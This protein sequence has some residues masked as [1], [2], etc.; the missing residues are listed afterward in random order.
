MR[1]RHPGGELVHL[2]YCTNV[3]PA[4]D[5]DGILAQL[6]TYALP[7][8]ERLEEP[9]L[10][11]GLWLAH[12]VAAALA[13]DAGL[14]AR[15]RAELGARGLEVVTLNG[16][17]YGGFHQ[18]VVK[19]DVYRPDWTSPER[20]RYTTDLAHV[21][22]RLLP[23]DVREGS[24]STLPLGWRT[25][26]QPHHSDLARHQIELLGDEL[27]EIRRRTGRTVRVAF[28]P[29]PGCLVET[30]GD[31]VRHLSD[32]D[33]GHFGLCLDICHLAVAFE[34]PEEVLNRLTAAG[35]PV[36]KAQ[37]SCALHA[38]NPADPGTR[39]ALAA[40]AEPRFLHQTRGAG[41]P[42]T[43]TDDLPEALAGP[44]VGGSPW[45]T[46]FHIP[47]HA[48]PVP[49]LA[50]T[51]PVLRS[52]L[53]ALLRTGHPVTR[54]F[55]TETYTWSVLPEPPRDSAGLIDG[56]AAELDWTRRELLGLGLSR[57][58]RR[59]APERPSE[60]ESGWDRSPEPNRSAR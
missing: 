35:I 41:P 25:G 56:I 17:P 58:E 30:S 9:V 53:A 20:R 45:R 33:P 47:V 24:I 18:P 37:V 19:H 57:P 51:R 46:H 26:W 49:P 40:F 27:A 28:E 12:Q 5:L 3:H 23:D 29:E 21:L 10:G 8:R 7:V 16:F 36:V 31:A 32:L 60:Q 42:A 34:T 22:A 52:A 6:D 48:D 38:E 59:S 43:G 55:E 54:H 14:A 50:S 2:G 1:L 11:V 13:A 15:L 4:E 39:A 44:A